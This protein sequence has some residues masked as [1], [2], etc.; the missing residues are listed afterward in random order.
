M[1]MYVQCMYNV[2]NVY[3]VYVQ[4]MYNVCTMYSVLCVQCIDTLGKSLFLTTCIIHSAY[5]EA[6][7]SSS[8]SL[9]GCGGRELARLL[10]TL[11]VGVVVATLAAVER[12]EAAVEVVAVEGETVAAAAVSASM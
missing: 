12:A 9:C 8:A 7:T 4:C 3:T 5:R 2:N 10:D 6:V 1:Y 11:V